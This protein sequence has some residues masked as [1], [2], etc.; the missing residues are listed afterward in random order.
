MRRESGPQ[1]VRDRPPGPPRP[2]HTPAC[3]VPSPSPRR[4]QVFALVPL[5][6]DQSI[7]QEMGSLESCLSNISRFTGWH[8]LKEPSAPSPRGQIF[9]LP[10]SREPGLR[11]HRLCPG[12][13]NIR[14]VSSS[15]PSTPPSPPFLC[16][17]PDPRLSQE[18]G[19]GQGREE[20][21][22]ESSQSRLRWECFL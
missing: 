5:S 8:I 3:A 17:N 6:C 12:K 21:K 13:E 16:G 2:L 15:L 18:A 4:P 11:P 1:D 7:A 9:R 20:G 10:V 14:A 19:A 22:T